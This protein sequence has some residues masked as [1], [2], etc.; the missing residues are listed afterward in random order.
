[1]PTVESG[2]VIKEVEK[3]QKSLAAQKISQPTTSQL[4]STRMQGGPAGY[5]SQQGIHA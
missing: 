5:A 2:S 4:T 1:M 3:Q